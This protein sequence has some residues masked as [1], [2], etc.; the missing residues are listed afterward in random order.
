MSI[1]GTPHV[2]RF[3]DNRVESEVW[4]RGNEHGRTMLELEPTNKRSGYAKVAAKEDVRVMA[5]MEED[6]EEG[7]RWRQVIRDGDP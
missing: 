7:G 6:T 1:R 5:V 2:D 4:R 3:G